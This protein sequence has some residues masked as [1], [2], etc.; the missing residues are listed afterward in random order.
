LREQHG[1]LQLQVSNGSS[2]PPGGLVL[3]WPY[4]GQPTGKAWLNGK[5]VGWHNG[6]IS[7]RKLPATLR[8]ERPR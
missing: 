2:L 3:P 4:A 5:P 7:I 6:E 8:I 1:E